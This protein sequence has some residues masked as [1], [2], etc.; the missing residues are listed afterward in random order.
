M[1][2]RGVQP[3]EWRLGFLLWVATGMTACGSQEAE[4]ATTA[5]TSS[6]IAAGSGAAPSQGS[7]GGAGA[8]ATPAAAGAG[9]KR[10]PTA[11]AAAGSSSAAGMAGRAASAGRDGVAGS[12][13]SADRAGVGGSAAAAMGGSGATRTATVGT[14]EITDPALGPAASDSSRIGGA[15]FVLV[16]NWDFGTNGT[17]RSSDDLVAEFVFH[18]SFNT[19][20]NGTHYG[21]V[22][23][24]PTEAT[25]IAANNLGLPNN[26]QPVEDPARPNREYTADTLKAH[27]LPLSASQSSA[28]A[29]AHSAGSGSFTAKWKLPNGGSL[30]HRDLLWETRVRFPAPGKAYWFSLWAAGSKW[31]G[32]AE[33]D[34]VESFGAPNTYPPANSFHVDPVGGSTTVGYSNWP[35]AL[36]ALGVTADKRDL[37]QWHTF[38]WFYAKDDT[39]K[40]YFDGKQVQSGVIHWTYG[41]GAGGEAI[42][43]EFLFDFGW[44]WV[45]S[46][47]EKQIQGLN[48]ELPASAFPITYEVDYSRV[49]LR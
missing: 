6:S 43:L 40:V 42:D 46:G 1:Q 47:S 39:Y 45:A 9:G 15:P 41:G 5:Q 21:A 2:T 44:G 28:S 7:A 19:I 18:D 23:V 17:I 22:M 34:V 25:A 26:K 30:L 8:A 35:N 29:P 3:G 10:G 11:G 31:N 20:A 13:G 24:A 38:S 27:V 14:G 16:K 48:T 32:G 12:A 49:Y 37:T 36:D 33:M 4:A